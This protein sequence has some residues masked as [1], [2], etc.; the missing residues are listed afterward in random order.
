MEVP[1]I[2][3]MD[4]NVLSTLNNCVHLS[5]ATN[6]IEKIKNMP[7]LRNLKILSL[8]RNKIR[9]IGGLEEIGETLE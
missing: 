9:K 5:L 7:A 8:S 2:E 6:A 3:Q 4:P 1:L